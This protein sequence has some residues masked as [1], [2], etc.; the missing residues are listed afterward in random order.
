MPQAS[1]LRRLLSWYLDL[2]VF[3]TAWGLLEYFAARWMALPPWVPYLA[4]LALTFPA[5]RWLGSP[6]MLALG[7]DRVSGAVT[8]P[9]FARESWLTLLLGVLFVLDG[10]KQLVRWTQLMVPQPFLFFFP[11]DDSAQIAISVASGALSVVA[12]WW[13]LKVDRRGLWLAL[14]LV[15]VYLVTVVFHWNTWDGIAADMVTQRRALQGLPVRPN[16][17]ERM[18]MIVPEGFAA[19]GALLAAGLLLSWRRFTRA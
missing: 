11:K 6:G 15:A 2:L 12:G 17:V 4:F 13:L 18:Q 10:T 5:R 19:L 7:I 8:A 3:L 16:E 9:A 14:A 1:W